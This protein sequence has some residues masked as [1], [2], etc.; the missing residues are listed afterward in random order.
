M[1]GG[2]FGASKCW[3]VEKFAQTADILTKK[4]NAMIIVSV[5]PD[6][7]EKRIAK[8]LCELAENRIYNLA[9]TPLTIS[10]LKTLFGR[11][12]LVISN[13]TGPRHIAI[14][15]KR[16]VITLFGPNDPA[17]TETGYENEV[18]IESVR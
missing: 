3:P 13:D 1:P 4:Y 7:E 8:D 14:G 9:Q 2:A 17:W 5:S 15:L 16:N 11:A 18:K 6:E 10:Q 12:N